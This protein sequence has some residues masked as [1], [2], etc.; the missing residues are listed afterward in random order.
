MQ[1]Y[2]QHKEDEYLDTLFP[3]NHI[4]VCIEIGAYDGISGSNSYF[5]ENKGW[6]A[7]CIEP[8]LVS[9]QQCESIRKECINCCISNEDS[10]DKEFHIFCLNNNN[11]S[12]ISGLEPDPRLVESHS[13][14]ITDR[15]ICNVKVRSLTSL[16][17]ELQY[18]TTIDFISIDTENTEL[19]VLKGIDFEKYNIKI[20]VIENNF[21]E[22]FCEEYLKQFGYKKIN[23][24]AVNDFFIKNYSIE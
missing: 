20:M 7:L 24:I 4:G 16:L 22:P 10:E 3:E 9:F 19:D 11:L 6:R 15:K 17:D 18:P 2:G 8:I 5:F 13:H 21:N 12:A 1:F 14:L 23:R